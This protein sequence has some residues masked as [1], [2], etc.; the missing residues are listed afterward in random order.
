MGVCKPCPAY[1]RSF[2]THYFSGTN[3][4]RMIALP[5]SVLALAAGVYL[6]VKVKREYL[7]GI[8]EFLAWLV[9]VLAVASVGYT[10][11]KAFSCKG[12]CKKQ[13]CHVEKNVVIKE[14]GKSCHGAGKSNCGMGGCNMEGCHMEGDSCVMDKAVCEKMMGKEACDSLSKLRG[15][16]IMSKEECHAMCGKKEGCTAAAP[17]ACC[18]KDG[19]GAAPKTCCKKKTE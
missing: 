10:G 17:T 11:V 4:K 8:F 18:K 6:L 7:G 1:P 5:L 14:G 3:Q 13:T 19:E 15:R 12:G 2:K 16:C 9:I